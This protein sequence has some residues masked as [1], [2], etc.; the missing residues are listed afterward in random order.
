MLPPHRR[1][2][3]PA[4][5]S[6]LGAAA[7]VVGGACLL[8]PSSGG[9]PTDPPA[10]V[11]LAARYVLTEVGGQAPPRVVRQ[12]ADGTLVRLYADTLT[13]TPGGTAESGTYDEVGVLGV[14]DPGQVERVTRV[15]ITG[16]RYT[17][18]PYGGLTFTGLAGS[19]GAGTPASGT[20]A[21]DGTGGT[22]VTVF[23]PAASLTYVSR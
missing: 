21:A 3:P 17:R 23:G 6:L 10:P 13:L 18:Q 7:T 19:G 15:V 4:G 20:V 11:A 8:F 5:A 16:E 9:G 2:L 12:N 14:I 22:V 1:W